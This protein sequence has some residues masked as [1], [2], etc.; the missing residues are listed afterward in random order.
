MFHKYSSSSYSEW[1]LEQFSSQSESYYRLYNVRSGMYLALY[2]SSSAQSGYIVRLTKKTTIIESKRVAWRVIHHKNG[3]YSIVSA[4]SEVSLSY[5]K[6]ETLHIQVS[7][8]RNLKC[9]H[10]YFHDYRKCKK[11][12]LGSS[13]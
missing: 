3:S 9:Q 1:R 8:Y 11:N 4:V 13:K 2:K 10:F 6:T 7:A 12:F 5:S